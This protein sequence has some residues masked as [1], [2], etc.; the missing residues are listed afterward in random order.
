MFGLGIALS[1]F[2]GSSAYEPVEFKGVLID[3]A[4]NYHSIQSLEEIVLWCD[5]GEVPF[6]VLHLT[7]DQNWMLPSHVV[8]TVDANNANGKPAYTRLELLRLQEFARRRGVTL[9][10]E[11]DMPGHSSLLVRSEPELF[12]IQGSESTNCIDFASPKVRERMN[13]LI[14]EVSELFSDSPYFHIGGDEAW[15]P[16]AEKDP[17]FQKA[18]AD[19]GIGADTHRVFAEFVGEMSDAVVT[20]GKLPMIWEGFGRDPWVKNR[21]PKEAVIIAWEGN[22]YRPQ[23]LLADGFQVFNA[24]WDPFYVVNHYP[25]DLM[26]LVPLER[27]VNYDPQK[28]GLVQRTEGFFDPI[29]APASNPF[30]GV[31]MC[32]WEGREWYVRDVLGP[33]ILALGLGGPGGLSYEEIVRRSEQ[34]QAGLGS[35]VSA[36]ESDVREL[37]SLTTGKR[38]IESHERDPQYGVNNLTDGFVRD[39]RYW[40]AFPAPMS[41]TID[42][43]VIESV[44]RIEVSVPLPG[45]GVPAYT[46]EWS[47]DGERWTRCVD[48]SANAEFRAT[49]VYEDSFEA[50][51]ARYLRLNLIKS[52]IHPSF[53]VRI[54]EFSAF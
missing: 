21:L 6:I 27:L 38:V 30:R 14:A 3:V 1:V 51:R 43:D 12:Q 40:L 52:S 8:H 45:R 16:N 47:L 39:D 7:D 2:A 5:A 44:S 9:I 33:R 53:M 22:Y 29:S 49:G 25:F 36:P 34:I 24:G 26:T 13:L 31:L 28:F 50:I 46:V 19:L 35:A 4:R 15:Y 17:D 37:K 48:R 10:P 20:N 18:I 11:V 41:A 23:D 42:L 54:C 32:W